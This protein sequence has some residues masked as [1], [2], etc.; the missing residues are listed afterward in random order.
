MLNSK[1]LIVSACVLLLG[2]FAGGFF[3][4]KW[5]VSKQYTASTVAKVETKQTKQV[6][7]GSVKPVFSATTPVGGQASEVQSSKSEVRSINVDSLWSEAKGYWYKRLSDSLH[8]VNLSQFTYTATG[9]TTY[10]LKNENNISGSIGVHV[11]YKSRLP[12]HP[13]AMF[14]ITAIP[15]IK[16]TCTSYTTT[17]VNTVEKVPALLIGAGYTF[18]YDNA[19]IHKDPFVSLQANQ[20]F[21]F[22]YLNESVLAPVR[23][24]SGKVKLIP[25][26]QV[27]I[28]AAL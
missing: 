8:S 7:E 1:F 24:E 23:I 13:D 17:V 25:Q 4:G 12:L 5:Y 20:K 26:L 16:S 6:L 21:M 28:A 19:V 18:S 2:G 3:T 14:D 9:D 11:V 10:N 15:D 27:C 22:L